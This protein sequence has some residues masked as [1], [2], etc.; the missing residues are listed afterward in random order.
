MIIIRINKVI[1]IINIIYIIIKIIGKFMKTY[2][3]AILKIF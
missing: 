2:I 3:I 1:I